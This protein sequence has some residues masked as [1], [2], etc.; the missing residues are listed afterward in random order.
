MN[1]QQ[2]LAVATASLLRTFKKQE[3]TAEANQVIAGL[4]RDERAALIAGWSDLVARM[5]FD[6]IARRSIR[7]GEIGRELARLGA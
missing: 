4:L 2:S 5:D 7:C 3:D 6:E 1:E